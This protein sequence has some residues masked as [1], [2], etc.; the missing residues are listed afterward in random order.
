MENSKNISAESVPTRT[1]AVM[2][3]QLWQRARLDLESVDDVSLMSAMLI[4]DMAIETTIKSAL[5][6][7]TNASIPELV[8][9]LEDT[10]PGKFTKDQLDAVKRLRRARNPVQHEAVV[11]SQASVARTINAAETFL[12]RSFEILFSLDFESVDFLDLIQDPVFHPLLV[13]AKQMQE[14]GR[15]ALCALF[16]AAGYEQLRLRWS[17][18][19]VQVQGANETVVAMSPRVIPL[20]SIHVFSN[21]Y[22]L[23]LHGIVK[24]EIGLGDKSNYLASLSGIGFTLV[25]SARLQEILR[26]A[27]KAIRTST[28]KLNFESLSDLD[29][30]DVLYLLRIVSRQ[31]WRLEQREPELYGPHSVFFSSSEEMKSAE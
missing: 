24:S 21:Q 26:K 6:E 14:D 18:V 31:V 27:M 3:K 29:V 7:K 30:D 17:D 28:E 4:A 25:E 9:A 5:S 12:R 1:L 2:I 15:T 10:Y 8:Q 20:V 23:D 13:K 22:G 19:F 11:L 16:I